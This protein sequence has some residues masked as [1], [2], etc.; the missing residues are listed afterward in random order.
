MAGNSVAAAKTYP[1]DRGYKRPA[2]RMGGPFDD[3]EVKEA[4]RTL[5]DAEKIKRNKALLRACKLEARKQVQ[6]AQQAVDTI[7]GGK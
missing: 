1:G 6:A 3:Y 5:T 7:Q 4:L 2:E